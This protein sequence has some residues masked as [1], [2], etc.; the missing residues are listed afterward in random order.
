MVPETSAA[1]ES[2]TRLQQLLAAAGRAPQRLVCSLLRNSCYCY[3]CS[4]L[5]LLLVIIIAV[6]VTVV[7]SI[8]IIGT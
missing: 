6:I 3:Y 4:V 5:F 7:I 8:D 1:S 2:P